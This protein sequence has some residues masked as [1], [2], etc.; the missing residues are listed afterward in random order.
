M[1]IIVKKDT[2]YV[3]FYF[4]DQDEVA[5]LEDRM[6]GARTVLGINSADYEIIDGVEPV[7]FFIHHCLGYDGEW[8]VY[9]QDLYDEECRCKLNGCRDAIKAKI[10]E[11]QTKSANGGFVHGDKPMDSDAESVA[12]ITRAI[13]ILSRS[14]ETT[15][16]V[17]LR[18]VCFKAKAATLVAVKNAMDDHHQSCQEQGYKLTMEADSAAT[19]AEINN[20]DIYEGWPLRG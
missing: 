20:I 18:T 4:T 5:L 12:I 1:K 17:N 14:K 2:K 11:R 3:A 9:D 7:E 8:F 6:V 19:Q 16:N 15:I 13:D 10:Y